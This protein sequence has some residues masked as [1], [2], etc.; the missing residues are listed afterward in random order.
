MPS[1]PNPYIFIL[2][3][4]LY[5]C[6]VLFLAFFFISHKKPTWVYGLLGKGIVTPK[7]TDSFTP[8]F[9]SSL[10]SSGAIIA[11]RF[12]LDTGII[13][14]INKTGRDLLGIKE[15]ANSG[16]NKFLHK[17]FLSDE[18]R[19]G[20]S[21]ELNLHKRVKN[22]P[23]TCSVNDSLIKTLITA[24]KYENGD[25]E[26]MIIDIT[27]HF[28]IYQ[29]I[30]DQ[31]I[32]LQNILN[33]L[34]VPVFV[35][36]TNEQSPFTN[37][38]FNDT[39]GDADN[40]PFEI[41]D[42]HAATDFIKQTLKEP[43]Y[44]RL[45]QAKTSIFQT[46][47]STTIND[48]FRHFEVQRRSLKKRNGQI[49]GLV[50]VATDITHRKQIE[51]DLRDTTRRYK[52]LFWN[53]A[54]GIATIQSDGRLTAV[55]PALATMFGYNS[56]KQL[57]ELVPNTEVIWRNPE[58][59]LEY[60]QMIH[61]KKTV[62]GYDFEFVRK[63]GTTGWMTISSNGKFD[64][65]GNL[66]SIESIVSDI[67]QKKQSEIE[68]K[69]CAT[70]DSTTEIS[71]RNALEGYLNSLLATKP[72]SAFAVVFIDLNNFKPIN[73]NHGHHTGDKVLKIIAQRLVA[74][75]RKVDFT[76][77]LG[78]D[79]F[80]VIL[81]GVDSKNILS[82][83]TKGLLDAIE[84]PIILAGTT[85]TISA[86]AGISQYPG[87]GNTITDLLK[88]ADASMYEMKRLSKA[89]KINDQLQLLANS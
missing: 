31:N 77:R 57:L 22:Y 60:L 45:R 35:R 62:I 68:L 10:Y 4:L 28:N 72:N 73:D 75:C 39:F 9:R 17:Q 49:F 5:T 40:D 24:E 66:K 6:A 20:L 70:I 7:E 19:E 34:P 2:A 84:K 55:N 53:A 29:Q 58:Q 43:E 44:T 89:S 15:T 82:K 81:N 41:Y 1:A 14:A 86:S 69:R 11:I 56:P 79:E 88:A 85:H 33:A 47:F 30:E 23:A 52:N 8:Q 46:E 51:Q 13:K 27:K 59:R 54:E 83:I 12:N 42:F 80:I 61:E 21:K 67:T 71:N 25:V 78:G 87:D 48:E 37:K 16:H 76:A 64:A 38:A 63:N 50:G 74:N 3:L 65:H 32:F 26:A 36:N 18:S